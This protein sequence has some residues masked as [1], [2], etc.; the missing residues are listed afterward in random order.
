[1]LPLPASPTDTFKLAD[2]LELECLL[3]KQKSSSAGDLTDALRFASL[4]HDEIEI[5]NK[6]TDVFDEL[7]QRSLS[8]GNSYP[9]ELTGNLVTRRH[10]WKKYRPYV[11]CLC[12][13]YFGWSTKKPRQHFPERLFEEISCYAAV[14]YL[15]GQDIRFGWPR[16]S[17]LTAN[18]GKALNLLCHDHI[19]EGAGFRDQ[20]EPQS[21]GD[22][23][24]DIVA[25]NSFPDNRPGKLLL[26]GA[27]AAGKDWED[28][29][30]D[31]L[32]PA[33]FCANCM[34]EIPPSSIIKA[35][36]IPHR[37]VPS[38]WDRYSRRAGVIFDRC[39]ISYWTNAKHDKSYNP[40]QVDSWVET[41]FSGLAQ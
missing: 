6:V 26:F 10:T 38:K 41:V 35:F 11:F 31:E 28:D 36:F 2:W 37:V 32:Q 16:H 4:F 7:E 20:D 18:F 39:R 17:P 19:K 1:M 34:I 27:C 15:H 25:W 23:C 30:M 8:A 40:D 21:N 3:S 5:E 22:G 29:K 14:N 24:L 9:F 12:L 33:T 13:S